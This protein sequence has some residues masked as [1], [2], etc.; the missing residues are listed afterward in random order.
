[1]KKD[2]TF[3]KLCSLFCCPPLPA[4]IVSKLAFRPPEPTYTFIVHLNATGVRYSLHLKERA[5]RQCTQKAL[6]CIDACLATTSEGN[7]IACCHIRCSPNAKYTILFSHPNACDLGQMIGDYFE[8]G[9]HLNCNVFSYDYSGYGISSGK[10]SEKC[11]YADVDAAFRTLCV[12]YRLRP[13]NIILYGQSIG[14]VPTVDLASRYEVG[15][16]ILH[17]PLMSGLRLAFPSRT[18]WFCDAFPRYRCCLVAIHCM[19]Y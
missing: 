3:A 11:L 9:L 13:K 2:L 5:A 8:L 12:R 14:T 16:V 18:T 15:G 7:R 10:P 4:K 6:D 1:M 17:S 19:L